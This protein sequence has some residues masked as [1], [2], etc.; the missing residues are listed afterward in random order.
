[1]AEKKLLQI[2]GISKSFHTVRALKKVDFEL[3]EGEIH[4][5]CGE[6]GAGKSTLMKILAGNYSADEGEIRIDGEVV[7][8][9]NP[10]DAEKLGIAIVYQETSLSPTLTVYEN[11]F[12]NREISFK[13]GLLN[14]KAMI[15]ESKKYLDMVGAHV[16]PKS[17]VSLLSVAEMQLVQIA[18]ALSLNARIL[19]MD[20]PC[21][22]LSEKDSENLFGILKSLKAKGISTIY[23]D[24]RLENF[25]KIGDRVT[26]FRDG[27]MIGTRDIEGMDMDEI[28][29][30][31]VGRSIDNIYP[32]TSTPGEKILLKMENFS[33]RRLKNVNLEVREG[34]ILGLGGLVG[35]GRSEIM[36]ALFGRDKADRGA[37][38]TL[39]GE[40]VSIKSPLDAVRCGIGYVPEDRK[41]QGLFLRLSVRF[42]SS[43]VALDKLSKG[44]FVKRKQEVKD[45]DDYIA[46]LNVKTRSATALINELSG[47][48]QQKVVLAKWLMLDNIRV[49]LL[50]EPTRG[51]DVGAKYE[52]YKLINSLAEK[53]IAVILITSELPEL[54]GL[55]DRI[56]VVRDGEISGVLNR[57]Q[58]S[59]VNVMKLSV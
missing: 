8:I 58:F 57:D 19:I 55:C 37:K 13:G 32:K 35:A 41:L 9:A 59:Q 4:I 56:A 22:A 23:I 3:L 40:V 11:I 28:I 2:Q 5:L 10:R 47:G 39:D 12:L 44:I 36:R 50:D 18:K 52:I 25:F 34:E 46:S 31:M 42:N 21:S 29:H 53:G 43:I 14:K 27:A 20:E 48:N 6:N 45:V 38:V 17:L 24:H 51:V 16:D 49:L 54:L 1:M 30:M 26:V 7:H 15:R 33:N